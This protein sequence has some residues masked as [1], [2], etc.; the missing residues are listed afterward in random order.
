M[1]QPATRCALIA[2]GT[3][4]RFQDD[5]ANRLV[6]VKADN[7]QTVIATYTYGDSNERLIL[8]EGGVRTYYARN[9]KMEYT[10]S[11]SST[12]PQWSK[13]Y[14]YLG[15]RLLSTLTPNGAGGEFIQYHHPDRLGTRLVTNAQNTTYFEQQTLPFG[16]ALNESP[17][18]GGV[19]GSTNKRFTT[20]DRSAITGLDYALNRH[21]DPQQGRF[22]QVDPIG[23]KSTSLGSP[24]TMNLYAYRTNDPINHTDPSGLGFIS[25]L[26]ELLNRVV[27]A[28]IHAA[29]TA[30]FTFIFTGGNLGAAIAAGAADFLKELGFPTNG[31][32]V[33]IGGTPQWNPN[34]V[35]TKWRHQ[36][37]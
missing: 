4:Q 32:G 1:T 9:G 5:A 8:E 16:T 2:G 13:S 17:P 24:Q 14:I 29:I 36:R 30:A 28:L 20:Y 19:T 10:E 15:A 23:M 18:T 21:Y 7:N 12:T 27:N 33:K 25:F 37:P 31:F 35:S 34:A 11:G 22:T 6:K 26:K 3:S